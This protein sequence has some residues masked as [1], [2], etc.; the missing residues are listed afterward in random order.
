M[1]CLQLWT[2][3]QSER[4]ILSLSSLTIDGGFL[5]AGDP[6]PHMSV[7]FKNGGRNTAFAEYTAF[8]IS[9]DPSLPRE[10]KY[11]S[12]PAFST[13]P[14]PADGNTTFNTTV[15][16]TRSLTS[17]EIDRIKSGKIRLS[18]FGYIKYFDTIWPFSS[19]YTGFCSVYMAPPAG[20]GQFY[21]SCPERDY[22]YVN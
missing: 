5:K 20:E 3:V 6:S 15:T 8:G 11:N 10:P 12:L 4:A 19:R 9:F 14:I 7:Q 1:A 18:I 17:D 2:F 22:T 21:N 13:Q 16:L